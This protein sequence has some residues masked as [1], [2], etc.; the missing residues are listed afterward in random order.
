LDLSNNKNERKTNKGGGERLGGVGS[1]VTRGPMGDGK[2]GE[3]GGGFSLERG[4][5]ERGGGGREET[6]S[7]RVGLVVSR[8][9]T[10]T[11]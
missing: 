1:V 8:E 5:S 3:K 11:A 4:E 2:Q 6:L 9:R 7:R 10:R